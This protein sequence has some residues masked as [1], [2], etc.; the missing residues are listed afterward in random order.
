[1]RITGGQARGIPLAT[2][3]N[4]SVR[5]ATDRMREAVFSSLAGLVEGARFYDLFAGSGG[6][7]LEAWSRGAAGGVLVEKNRSLIRVIESN[8]RV[9]GKSLNRS[10]DL[11][12]VA[13]SDVMVWRP[14]GEDRADLIFVDPPYALIPSMAPGLFSQFESWLAPSG[15]V[16]FEM[17]GEV[18]VEPDRWVCFKRI[19][20]GRHQ[21]SCCFFRRDALGKE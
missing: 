6:Y 9:V 21:P 8:V 1:M 2:G 20:K 10:P 19:G 15:V 14:H 17:P 3:K 7:G 16:I 5:P 11:I 12:Q 18:T 13:A 4:S